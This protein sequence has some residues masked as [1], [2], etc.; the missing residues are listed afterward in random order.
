MRFSSNI[1]PGEGENGKDD[2]GHVHDFVG[3]SSESSRVA[4]GFDPAHQNTSGFYTAQP[5]MDIP[6][7]HTERIPATSVLS[8]L[9][10]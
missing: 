2:K 10:M 8:C 4:M 3:R 6:H 1:C 9:Y 5:K 7:A